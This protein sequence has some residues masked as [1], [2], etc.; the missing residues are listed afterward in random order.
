MDFPQDVG[1]DAIFCPLA[2]Y[3][4][5][6][7]AFPAAW[8]LAASITVSVTVSAFVGAEDQGKESATAATELTASVPGAA[9]TV[10]GTLSIRRGCATFPTLVCQGGKPEICLQEASE[11]CDIEPCIVE[12]EKK[13]LQD[14]AGQRLEVCTGIADGQLAQTPLSRKVVLERAAITVEQSCLQRLLRSSEG[15]CRRRITERL[16]RVA[17]FDNGCANG[18]ATCVSPLVPRN[19][20]EMVT[21]CSF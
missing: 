7:I 16:R 6:R 11:G 1:D 10:A 13:H 4:T 15:E 3:R 18:A 21:F 8:F 9:D 17:Q 20:D 14:I 19:P 5:I 2:M 12:H